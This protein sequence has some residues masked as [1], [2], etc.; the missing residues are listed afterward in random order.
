MKLLIHCYIFTVRHFSFV[1]T[2]GV[3]WAYWGWTKS[4]LTRWNVVKTCPFNSCAIYHY[5][6]ACL[7]ISIIS[8]CCLESCHVTVQDPSTR[9]SACLDALF[10][11]AASRRNNFFGALIRVSVDGM[12]LFWKYWIHIHPREQAGWELNTDPNRLLA[13][14]QR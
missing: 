5:R 1:K 6:I 4:S 7:D 13:E 14:N 11:H 8:G 12:W 3:V 9:S 2:S 10:F